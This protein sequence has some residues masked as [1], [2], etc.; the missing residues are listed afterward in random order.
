MKNTNSSNNINNNPQIQVD[1]DFFEE[2]DKDGI[3]LINQTGKK[4]K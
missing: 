1:N 3:I 4:T 2:F